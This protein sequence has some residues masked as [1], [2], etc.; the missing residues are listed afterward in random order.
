MTRTHASL[1][2]LTSL[3][4]ACGDSDPST[5]PDAN[6]LSPDAIA[7]A[8]ANESTVPTLYRFESRFRAGESSISYSGQV[9]RQLLIAE[10]TSYVAGL[11]TQVDTSPP[12][13]GDVLS[14]LNFYFDFNSSTSGDTA[15][16]LA[17]GMDPPALQLTF[18]DV[19]SDKN[20]R[21]KLAG[22]DTTT[23]HKAWNTPSEFAGWSEG[24]TDTD[25]P[26]KLVQ[27]WFGLLD[28]LA[29]SRIGGAPLDPDNN[30]IEKVY[31]TAKGQDLQQL[32]QKFLLGAVAFSQGQDDYL[33]N[34]VANK[35]LLSP[36]TQDDDKPYSKLE[37]AWDE[38]FGYFGA[39]RNYGDYTDDELAGKGGR[40][41]YQGYNDTDANNKIDLLAEFNFGNSTNCAKR[42]RSSSASAPTDFTKTIFDAFI[43]GRHIIANAGDTLTSEEMTALVEQRDIASATWEQCVA[44]TVIHYI[45]EVIADM[46]TFE[47]DDYSFEGHAKH[48]SELKGFALGLQFNPRSPMNEGTKFSDFHALVGDAPV[49]PNDIRGQNVISQYKMDL[50]TARAILGTAYSFDGANVKGW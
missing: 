18:N 45:N 31:V 47:T 10:L 35:G 40:N 49:L 22:N 34:D 21:D 25:T 32:I 7:S 4:V 36:N 1:A 41:E 5:S 33:D 29:F 26:T 9:F 39:A 2:L 15:L 46:Q 11:T 8:D 17:E 38:G 23:D 50:E 42:D 37:H 14:A 48:W 20:L 19:S 43:Q 13:D 27:Y 44:A 30:P 16:L 6:S 12:D 3:L 28:D 24:G